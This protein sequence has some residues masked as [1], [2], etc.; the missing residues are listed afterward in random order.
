MDGGRERARPRPERERSK[1]AP[2]KVREVGPPA[3]DRQTLHRVSGVPTAR[4][5]IPGHEA[6]QPERPREEQG[7][8]VA[9]DRRPASFLIKVFSNGSKRHREDQARYP[10]GLDTRSGDKD[11]TE[12]G[13]PADD[14]KGEADQPS[15]LRKSRA[16]LGTA[17]KALHLARA[18][19]GRLK[20]KF[21][22]IYRPRI[23]EAENVLDFSDAEFRECLQALNDKGLWMEFLQEEG[24]AGNSQARDATNSLIKHIEAVSAGQI[25]ED[26][27]QLLEDAIEILL[28]EINA[29]DAKSVSRQRAENLKDA[30]YKISW[31]VTAAGAAIGASS[32]AGGSELAARAI[33]AG[34]AGSAASIVV[35]AVHDYRNQEVTRN[36]SSDEALITEAHYNLT[37][38]IDKIV[39]YFDRRKD[40]PSWTGEEI[41]RFRN[42][43]LQAR[44][45]AMVARQQLAVGNENALQETDYREDLIAM[46]DFLRELQ[47][48]IRPI[49]HGHLLE[50]ISDLADL[51][52]KLSEYDPFFTRP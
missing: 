13:R 28:S 17:R 3:S 2:P 33:M 39:L 38:Q 50:A 49:N 10:E 7:S 46:S 30:A 4:H 37:Q 1:P 6:N 25:S 44:F 24:L 22:R 51:Q 52:T 41:A 18:Q 11:R 29:I 40:R 31:Q 35:G 16:L 5:Q 19:V 45:A 36:S 14:T 20:K 26:S 27:L 34:L 21:R 47:K 15:V 12:P 32:M 8:G 23:A 48:N 9:D 42:T 43:F